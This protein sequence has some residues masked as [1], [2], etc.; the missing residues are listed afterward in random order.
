[1]NSITLT[2][3]RRS[4]VNTQHAQ[5]LANGLERIAD[6]LGQFSG[7]CHNEYLN[8][9]DTRLGVNELLQKSQLRQWLIVQHE[10]EI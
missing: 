9:N 4:T 8:K 1:M 2:V 5:T 10:L 3:D 7:R 6:L